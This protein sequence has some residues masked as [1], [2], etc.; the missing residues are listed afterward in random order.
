MAKKNYADLAR[1]ITPRSVAI[2][3]A[4]DNPAKV[5]QVIMKNYIDVGFQGN[6]YPININAQEKIMGRKAYKSILEV[7]APIDL[8]V[9]CIPAEFVPKT[10][11]QCG[12]A[13]VN[14]VV[15]VSSGF[16]EVGNQKL[17]DQ[18]V[19]AARKYKLPVIGPNC[20][21]VMDPR[22]RNDTLFLPTSKID[23]PKIGYISFASQSGAVGST[24]LDLISG[25]SFGLSKF[26]SYGNAAVVDEVDVLHYLT[27]DVLTKVIVYY[28]E[29]VNRGK[30]FI[31]A[32]REA[33][34][35]KPV[36][37]IKGGITPAG[38]TAAHS[39]TAALAGSYEA[40]EAVF[41]QY[42]F[43]IAMD[44]DDLLYFA[45]IFATQPLSSGERIAVLTN[46]GGHGVLATDALYQNGLKLAELS[47][48][49]QKVLKKAM[50]SFVNIA[51]PFDM[52]GEA[53]AD[54]YAKALEVM[55]EDKGID[56]F[57]VIALFQT[58][59]ADEKLVQ[60]LSQF[61]TTKKKPMVVISSGATYTKSHVAMLEDAG[62]P[63]YDSPTSAARSL[64]A[65]INYSKYREAVEK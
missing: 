27:E 18:F 6:I 31:E 14:G 43:S 24:V 55:A 37:I 9:I 61:S 25:E 65:L 44:L 47:K 62:V 40:Y 8:A 1:I 36:V 29:G 41:R 21:G 33:T 35:K 5:G 39:H 46:G 7:K 11:E 28:L 51:M 10:I 60:V 56:A 15:V 59:G 16:A 63:V 12:K 52:S 48:E 64:R 19:A 54:S 32:A 4:S 58:P 34:K 45:K 30:E 22:S 2:I 50:P 20:L 49:S 3:G 57:M 42:G 26:I 53:T 38:V 13:R 23:R 17:Q